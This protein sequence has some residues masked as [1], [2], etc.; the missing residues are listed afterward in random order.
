VLSKADFFKM[1]GVFFHMQL[2]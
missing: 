2:S 1:S